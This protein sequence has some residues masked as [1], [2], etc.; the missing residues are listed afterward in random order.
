MLMFA[1]MHSV[2]FMSSRL[3]VVAEC[4]ALEAAA[5]RRAVVA[6]GVRVDGRG[7]ADVRPIAA[8]CGPL[9]RVHGSA[10]FTRG[11][12]QALCTATLGGDKARQHQ[13]TLALDFDESGEDFYLHYFFPPSCV[14]E[15]GKIAGA[16]RR[17]VGHGKLAERALAPA[18]RNLDNWPYTMRIESHI[19]ES[20]GSSSMAS[21]CGA[22]LALLV[23]CSS[24][25]HAEL[26]LM[27]CQQWTGCCTSRGHPAGRET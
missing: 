9:P 15:V 22:C 4:R 6:T 2:D 7:L 12:T 14:G 3:Q 13:E 24:V 10:L 27:C 5:A 20:N 16:G 1:H 8:R 26:L 19:T 21:V 23:R 25:C 18:L 11:S 17:E